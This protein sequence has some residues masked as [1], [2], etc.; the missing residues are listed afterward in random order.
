MVVLWLDELQHHWAPNLVTLLQQNIGVEIAGLAGHSS[1]WDEVVEL[2]NEVRR[3]K[4]C[5]ML[6]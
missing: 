6:V 3:S 1:S 4:L 5:R 2:T